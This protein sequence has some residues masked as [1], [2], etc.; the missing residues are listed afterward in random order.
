M[1][2]LLQFYSDSFQISFS[3]IKYDTIRLACA[4]FKDRNIFLYFWRIFK[5]FKIMV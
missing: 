3:G 4:S 1:H 2:L 5:C